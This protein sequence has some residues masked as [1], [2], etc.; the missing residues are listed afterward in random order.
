MAKIVGRNSALE[1]E[2]TQCSNLSQLG[3]GVSVVA[4][5]LFV[6]NIGFEFMA[7]E[8]AVILL[9]F[10][11]GGSFV[12]QHYADKAAMLAAGLTG[13][14]STAGIISSLPDTYCGFQNI[15][16][17]YEGKTS[18]LDM[19]VTGPTGVF[20]IET[21]NMNGTIVGNYDA[22]YWTQ[23]KIGR[24]GTPYSGQLYSP[25]KQVK[26]HVYRLANYLRKENINVFVDA[27]VYFSNPN[28]VVQVTGFSAGTPVFSALGNGSE[29][30]CHQ[31]LC[32]DQKLSPEVLAKVNT[33]LEALAEK[34]S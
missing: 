15:Q 31:I 1:E 17:S 3:L 9:L 26:T 29:E 18:E 16:V 20:I 24:N 28:S 33:L 4:V 32:S 34:E 11:A 7:F 2:F 22:Q 27:M 13:E 21:K 14:A 23:R 6:L 30:I 5:V 8:A 10:T 12:R 19:V 25:V